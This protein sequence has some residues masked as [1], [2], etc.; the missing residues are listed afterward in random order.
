[1]GYLLIKKLCL[2]CYRKDKYRP[3][4]KRCFVNQCFIFKLSIKLKLSIGY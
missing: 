4:I 3:I 1:M 2:H